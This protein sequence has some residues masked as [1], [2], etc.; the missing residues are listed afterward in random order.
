MSL[1]GIWIA[2]KE[3]FLSLAIVDQI[4]GAILSFSF[5]SL[6]KGLWARIKPSPEEKA[7][8]RALKKWK[9]HF[10][11]S[12]A[13]DKERRLMSISDFSNYVITHHGV[14]DQ[15]IDSLHDF[16]ERELEKTHEGKQFLDEL[17]TK[18]LNKDVYEG[19]LKA[20]EI[21]KDLKSMHKMQEAI[22][23]EL[24]THNKGK[25][26]F[27]S[28]PGYI[29]R[30]CTRRLKNDEV[31]SYLL[32]HKTFE[33]YRLVD[34][35]AGRTECKGNKFILYSDAQTGKTTELLQLGWELQEEKRLIPI[36]FK[37]R[38]CQDIKQELPAL[39]KEI[40]K[41]LVVIIDALDEKFEGDARFGLYNEIESYAEEHPHLNIVVTCRANFSGEFTFNGFKELNLSDLSWQD[42]VDY[43]NKEGV[44]A[45]AEEIQRA[46]LYEFVRTPFYL[47]ALVDYYKEK[48]H[49]P[50]N[51]GELYEFFIDRRLDQEEKLRLK[52]NSEMTSRGKMLLGKMAV[53]IQLMGA[54][55]IKKEELL[56]LYDNNYDDYNRVLRTGLTEP[57]EED[58]CSFTHNSFKEFFVSRYLL[59]LDS[60]DEIQ[61]LSCYRGTQIVKTGWYNTIALLLAQLPKES[62]L[63]KQ[64]L[65]WIVKDNKK[66]VLCIDR[67]LFDEKQRTDIFKDIIGWHKSKY[68]RIA[69][70]S[71]STYEDLMN[72]GRS[73][74]SIDYL[75]NELKGCDEIDNHTVNVLF[76]LRYL[77]SG[78]LTLQEAAELRTLLLDAFMKFKEDG[79]HIYVLFEVFE[80]PWLKNE[81]NAD[82]IYEIEKDSEHPNIVNHLVEYI[83]DT[84]CAEKYVDVIID[85][86]Q[87]IGEYN[88]GGYR[89]I[90]RRD[91]LYEAY[92][93]LTTWDSI[94]KVL[95]QL[96]EEFVK[97]LCGSCDEEKFEEI[98]A[99]MLG[100]VEGL[101]TEHSDAPDFVYEMLLEMAEERYYFRK[102]EKDAFLEFF[103]H[104][105]LTQYYFDVSMVTLKRC[106]LDNTV[107]W[108][109]S[110]EHKEIESKAYCAGLMLNEERLKQVVAMIDF[111]NPNGNGLLLYLSQYASEDLQKRID[112][113]RKKRYPQYWNDNNVLEKWELREQQE[114]D[115]LMD[116]DRFKEKV[117][118]IIDEKAPQNREEMRKLRNTKV[119]FTVEEEESISRYVF[120]VFYKFYDEANDTYN[121]DQVRT[122]IEDYVEYQKYVV[123]KT[124]E[125]LYS[126]HNKI[127]MNEGQKHLFR[128]A[129]ANWLND[130]AG[131]PFLPE[132]IARLQPITVLLHHDVNVDDETVLRLLPYTYC[133]IYLRTEGFNGYNYSLFDYACERYEGRQTELLNALR[134]VMDLPFEYPVQN[135]KEWCIY[136]IKKGISS[137]YDRAVNIMLSLP[138]EDPAICITQALVDNEET[139]PMVLKGDVWERCGAEKRFFIYEHL[140]PDT[141]MDEFVRDGLEKDFDELDDGYKVRAVRLLLLKG[142]VKGLEYVEEHIHVIDMRSDLRK[143][144]IDALPL[145]ISAYSKAIDNLHHSDY[146]GI[147]NA[148]SAIAGATDE[149]WE[150]VK[151]AFAEL[152]EKDEKKFR[153]LNWYLRDWSVK[154]ME[155]ASPVMTI[156]EVKRLIA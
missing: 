99:K 90:I 34:V 138:C 33:K 27:E 85:K 46:R 106:F 49:L 64:I 146:G 131:K 74:E 41:G 7:F 125:H 127:K 43:L 109:S 31:F 32:E 37:V 6:L 116:Y 98:M 52:Q 147:L 136:L 28:V 55:S 129:V 82:A 89:R 108:N 59:Q 148:V 42:S 57:A 119:K 145:L 105:G 63:S 25:R 76:L 61:K 156:E 20:E 115:E 13:Y 38:G 40:E 110:E 50:E 26:E 66:M 95:I 151:K 118:K 134:G 92:Q 149:G 88:H 39:N 19:L 153:H 56:I 114:Y 150:K 53:A 142:S 71:S 5:D 112:S 140:S 23:K 144:S 80:S 60:F 3:W 133:H 104:T 103:E 51:K 16:F 2:I 122:Y 87:F 18:A 70:Y 21:L 102:F 91:E 54:N 139:R 17:R 75:K 128:E 73:A 67:K 22:W 101:V 126:D 84:G 58:G 124:A 152:I 62:D 14:Y 12:G 130:L 11:L 1:L 77:R 107:T 117:L 96:K 4:F 78:D 83:T 123:S 111:G 35:I 113:I 30:Y 72:F 137:E 141:T 8:K 120:G 97:H 154:R 79:E 100:K 155:K 36:M 69:D 48:K 65:A 81:E 93:A 143:Y 47:I 68:L 15:Y 24:N 10:H 121:L 132:Q 86:G 9:K 135:W 94:K 44:G 45:I 29:Q